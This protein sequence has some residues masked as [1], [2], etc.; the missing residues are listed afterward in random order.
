[1]KTI[2]TIDFDIIMAPSINLYNSIVGPDRW[3][4][5]FTN[6]PQLALSYADL[7]HYHKLTQYLLDILPEMDKAHI[8]FIQDHEKALKYIPLGEPIHLVNID[9]HHDIGYGEKD[10]QE[11][12]TRD[13]L[14][15]GNW[16]KYLAEH[17]Q[18]QHFHWINNYNS[19][20]VEEFNIA[21]N[22]INQTSDIRSL[23]TLP[24][25]PD[26]LI[27]CLS[28]MWVPPNYRHLFYSWLDICNYI[29][30]THYEVET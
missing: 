29:H 3:E 19:T 4:E 30:H 10:G 23:T 7:K 16:V 12:T 9:H 13:T 1:M 15:C 2:V 8:H 28:P 17:G 18:L 25:T 26:E 22:K 11:A 24:P 14:T 20:P 6:N 27:I 5:D 21:K